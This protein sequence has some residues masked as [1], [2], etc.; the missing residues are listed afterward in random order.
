[1]Q[2]P[3]RLTRW[4]NEDY[5]SIH[6]IS[7]TTCSTQL[8]V[9]TAIVKMKMHVLIGCEICQEYALYVPHPPITPTNIG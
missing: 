2:A 3:D 1:M 5:M 6:P 4:Y 8:S 9:G 7:C